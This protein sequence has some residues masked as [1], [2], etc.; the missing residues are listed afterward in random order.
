MA[1]HATILDSPAKLF[2]FIWNSKRSRVF[3]K[4]E[5]KRAMIGRPHFYQRR[6]SVLDYIERAVK[7]GLTIIILWIDNDPFAEL[8]TRVPL[9]MTVT[10]RRPV[11][12][13]LAGQSLAL[14]W[15]D[16]E[17]RYQDYWMV[18]HNG[19]YLRKVQARGS[20]SA[21]MA[22]QERSSAFQPSDISPAFRPPGTDSDDLSPY[23]LD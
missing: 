7:Q 23:I 4:W 11:S 19:G 18:W 9:M 22:H 16:Q 12:D 17:K 2:Q 21:R 8:P 5:D 15:A 3:R 14:I 6:H 20:Q 10:R 1:F 13:Y